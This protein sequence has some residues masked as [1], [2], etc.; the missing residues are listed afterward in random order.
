[1]RGFLGCRTLNDKMRKS[2]TIDRKFNS[3]WLNL[4]GK[5]LAYTEGETCSFGNA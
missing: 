4:K 2:L 5:S 3:N 1:M